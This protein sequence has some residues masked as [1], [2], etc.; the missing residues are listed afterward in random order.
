[1]YKL[2]YIGQLYV[3]ALS[4]LGVHMHAYVLVHV[5]GWARGSRVRCAA[6]CSGPLWWPLSLGALGHR[7]SPAWPRDP[8][9]EMPAAGHC[10]R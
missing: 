7:R 2:R 5:P 6:C 3:R 1:M 4:V 9:A 10:G 8:P